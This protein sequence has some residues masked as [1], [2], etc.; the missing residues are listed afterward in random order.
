MLTPYYQG[1]ELKSGGCFIRRGVFPGQIPHFL[2]GDMNQDG[3]IDLADAIDSL[4]GIFSGGLMACH[5]AA[6][7]NDDGAVDVS[8]P[9]CALSYLFA[10]GSPPAL[11]Y[12][13]CGSD[14]GHDQLDCGQP[15]SCP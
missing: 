11:P 5:D 4:Q 3:V 9:I 1:V 13:Q 2:R 6:D 15:V 14:V 12:P 10:G 8:D 7:W